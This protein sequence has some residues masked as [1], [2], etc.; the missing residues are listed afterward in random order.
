MVDDWDEW[1]KL[2][3]WQMVV[4]FLLLVYYG[5]YY[6]KSR[7]HKSMDSFQTLRQKKAK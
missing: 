6:V 2:R 1:T 5:V 7:P 4:L 3:P